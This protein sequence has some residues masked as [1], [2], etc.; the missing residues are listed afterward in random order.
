MKR[1]N[2]FNVGACVFDWAGN[3]F[4][5]GHDDRKRII[6]IQRFFRHVQIR[7]FDANLFI[8]LQ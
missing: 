5:L 4:Q 2:D 6:K 3:F 1:T 7:A 8:Y